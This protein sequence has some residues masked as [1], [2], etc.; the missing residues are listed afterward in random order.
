MTGQKKKEKEEKAV[1]DF[2]NFLMGILAFWDTSYVLGGDYRI[3]R[4][5]GDYCWAKVRHCSAF[6]MGKAFRCS[7]LF[8]GGF[9]TGLIIGMG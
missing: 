3:L 2:S 4:T 7:G 9:I 8:V 6:M 5:F 1:D